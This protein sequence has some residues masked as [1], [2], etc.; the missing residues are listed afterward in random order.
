[1]SWYYYPIDVGVGN[2]GTDGGLRQSEGKAG[3]EQR[4]CCTRR[5]VLTLSWRGEGSIGTMAGHRSDGQGRPSVGGYFMCVG[6]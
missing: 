3:R 6:R 1:M 4:E 2:N 5:L